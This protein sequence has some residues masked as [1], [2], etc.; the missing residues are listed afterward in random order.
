MSIRSVASSALVDE[1]RTNTKTIRPYKTAGQAAVPLSRADEVLERT[2]AEMRRSRRRWMI[3]CGL[4]F[5]VCL[6]TAYL[7][8]QLHVEA[9][10]GLLD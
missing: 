8:G 9:L 1:P 6:V 3:G 2:W 10:P 7:L 5:A 4:A